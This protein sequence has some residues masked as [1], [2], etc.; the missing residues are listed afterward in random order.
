MREPNKFAKEQLR[1][2][3]KDSEENL[4]VRQGVSQ[5]NLGE[6]RLALK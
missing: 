6:R 4:L 2:R 1:K 3:S 5:L